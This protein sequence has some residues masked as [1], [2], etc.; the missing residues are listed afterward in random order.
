MEIREVSCYDDFYGKQLGKE[1]L[2]WL[3]S[4]PERIEGKDVYL[5]PW[6]D[7]VSFRADILEIMLNQ[8]EIRMEKKGETD[9][10]TKLD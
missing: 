9:Y 6:A 3:K 2:D 5:A 10:E 4:L 8:Y 7:R 1:R